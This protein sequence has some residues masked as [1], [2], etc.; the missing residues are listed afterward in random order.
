L[1]LRRS[2][3]KLSASLRILMVGVALLPFAAG[4]TTAQDVQENEP[5]LS[6]PTIIGGEGWTIPETLRQD[7]RLEESLDSWGRELAHRDSLQSELERIHGRATVIALRIS[8]L[9]RDPN[10]DE[11]RDRGQAQRLLSEGEKLR[12]QDDRISVEL[13]LSEERI[14]L[15]ARELAVQLDVVLQD[16]GDPLP[17]DVVSFREQLLAW[18]GEISFLPTVEVVI[19]PDDTPD[20]LREKAGYLRDLA[21][22]LDNLADRLQSKLET[23][24]WQQ[25]LLE[26]AEQVLD[27]AVFLDEGAAGQDQGEAPLRIKVEGRPGPPFARPTSVILVTPEQQLDLGDLL[28]SEP[29]S[30]TELESMRTLLQGAVED[31]AFQRDSIRAQAD[32]LEEEATLREIP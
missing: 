18:E 5:Q 7:P 12:E 17:R 2:L 15:A 14:L 8:S 1:K 28:D 19:R 6:P 11:I 25:R 4:V 3:G 26:G 31:V 24:H 9:A 10:T 23:L 20:V 32:R 30:S 22:G 13:A 16:M 29:S 27:D 21:D